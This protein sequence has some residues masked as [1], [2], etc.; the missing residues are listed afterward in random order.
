[1]QLV[2]LGEVLID[3]FPAEVGRKLVDVSAFHPKPGGAPANV[4]VAARRL[5]A[6][7]AFIGKVGKDLFGQHLIEV[8]QA[9]GVDTSGMRVA[10]QARTTMA[11][12]AMPDENTAEFVFYRNPGADQLL[13]A[14]ELDPLLLTHTR[15]FH[16]GSLSLTGEPIR[17]A[18]HEAVRIA[19]A[20][21]ALIS[22]DMNYRP[23][24]WPN[25]QAAVEATEAILPHVD[26]VKVNQ[27][28]LKLIVDQPTDAAGPGDEGGLKQA[29]AILL[30]KGPS[31]VVVTFGEDGSFFHTQEGA[32]MVPGFAVKTVD[33]TGCGDAF[34]AGLLT[35][36][37]AAHDW[38]EMLLPDCMYEALRYANAV[39]ALTATRQGV[40]PAL[41]DAGE[42]KAFLQ[43]E[44]P[45]PGGC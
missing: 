13:N 25:P 15:A 28:E 19:R 5:G 29:T 18:T 16:F 41:P 33:A 36:L 23:A 7:A 31:V 39:G 6:E 22:Y 20:S 26:V 24:L 35:R 30:D 1:M 12:I 34:I 32:G 11:V 37:T 8:L 44:L 14:D 40:I 21:G 4:A 38:R 3:M 2:T 45:S 9:E 17:T 10:A 27:A 42:V 43:T